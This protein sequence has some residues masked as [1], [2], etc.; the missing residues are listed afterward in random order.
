MTKRYFIETYGCQMNVNDS[1]R[2]AGL[3]AERGYAA[4]EG[5]ESADVVF[6]NTC[7][8]REKAAEKLYSAV[9]RLKPLKQQG[10]R[11]GVGGCV[12]QL[13]GSEVL[14]R[15]PEID[16]L[17]GTHTLGRFAELLEAAD[18]GPRVDLDRKADAFG[19][20]S[21]TI[22]RANP[23]RAYVTIMEGCNHVCSFCVV[24]RTRGIE[25]CRDP[26]A[27]V[28]E[29]RGLAARGV[30]EVMLLGQTVN[31]YRS[32]GTGFV[33]LL[34]RVDA[35]EGLHRL[36]FTTSHPSHMTPDV[37]RGLGRL[38]RF[39]P[40]IH[41]PVQSGSDAILGSMRRGYSAAQYLEIAAS[42]RSEIRG[43]ALSSDVI[44]GYPGETES[45]FL[46]TLDL[47]ENAAFDGLFTFTY[48]PRP[49][50]TAL[51]LPD[52][53]PEAE[54]KRRLHA[55]DSIQQ[56][57]QADRHQALVGSRQEVLV[58]ERR[59]GELVGR[60]PQ[61]KLVHFED[62]R[63]LLGQLVEVLVEQA[64]PNSLRG[65]AAS[66]SLTGSSAVPIF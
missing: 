27:V 36:R 22:V 21:E 66:A 64:G 47:V 14:E 6:I 32:G 1:E 55:L 7:A 37:A 62:P 29:V 3:L 33:E 34:E 57:R 24:P 17:V 53:V 58:E 60:S 56:R 25:V 35:V 19:L 5:P 10:L 16:V 18:S 23:Y 65:R 30:P 52:D 40:Y 20:P 41:L 26:A 12:A 38:R 13:H 54:K 45:D 15:A 49:G 61:F 9:G 59:G 48:S 44:V 2:V 28:A 8:V 4:A 63:P 51:R 46:A 43:L 50:T 11:I 31:A 42:L 39:A